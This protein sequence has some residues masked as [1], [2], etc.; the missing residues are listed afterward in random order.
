MGRDLGEI[1]LACRDR[2]AAVKRVR[3]R[4]LAFP[5]MR[6]QSHGIGDGDINRDLTETR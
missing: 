5:G 4:Q 2:R 6:Y 1:L 3:Q